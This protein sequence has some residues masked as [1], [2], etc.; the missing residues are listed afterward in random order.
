MDPFESRLKSL[1]LRQP[2]ER[3]GQPETLARFRETSFRS[4]TI[5]QRIN[6]M[7]GA[8][9]AAT[10]VAAATIGFALYLTSV[11]PAGSS[12][13]F[14]Q[15]AE[16]LHMAKTV[17][18]DSVITSVADGTTLHKS[19]DYYMSPGKS[20]HEALFPESEAGTT[21]IED[22]PA[23]KSIV[24]ISKKKTVI[25]G[26]IA[27]G[28]DLDRAKR[29]TDFLQALREKSS[30]KLGEKQIEGIRASGFEVDSPEET[31]TVWADAAT[32]NP[33]RIEI[34]YKNARPDAQREVMTNI[35]LDEKLDPA[36]FGTQPP[37]GYI[38]RPG[39]TIDLNAGPPRYV[40][41][42]LK[43][44]AKYMD[45]EFPATLSKEGIEPLY[46]RLVKTGSLNPD[47]FPAENDL[48]QLPAYAAAVAAITSKLKV[49]ERWQYY[50]G[51]TIT[52]KDRIVFWYL[53]AKTGAYSAVYG[54]LRIN[55]VAK[56]M[57]P[58]AQDAER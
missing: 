45:G 9:K 25:L 38:V 22:F 10:L 42:L 39:A 56:D 32:G 4:Q 11:G 26:S 44:Y 2:S 54:D 5:L 57:L 55:K 21:V 34:L 52:N 31:T 17:S 58:L 20:R 41:E 27:V 3:F 37:E 24:V 8:S 23:G 6:A 33:V 36:M 50:P 43:T 18:F 49:G 28:A 12:A 51:F 14:A 29:M 15:V 53:D 47:E 16:R 19:R 35:G 46:Q 48:L 40:A 1:P 30:Q 13:A 7:P